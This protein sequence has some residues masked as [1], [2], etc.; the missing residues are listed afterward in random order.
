MSLVR[1][2]LPREQRR[3]IKAAIEKLYNDK[4]ASTKKSTMGLWHDVAAALKMSLDRSFGPHWH[5]LIGSALGFALKHR[6]KTSAVWRVNSEPSFTVV[7]WKSPGYEDL[8][9]AVGLNEKEETGASEE[10]ECKAVNIKVLQPST[11]EEDTEIEKCIAL[12]R[13]TLG[14]IGEK[15]DFQLLAESLRKCFTT[16]MGPV[17]HISVGNDIIAEVATNRRSYFMCSSGKLRIIGFKHEQEGGSTFDFAKIL[18]GIPYALIVIFG[19]VYLTLN[20]KC[21][22]ETL[23]IKSPFWNQVCNME[24]EY[25]LALGGTG[26]LV[27]ISIGKRL[28]RHRN[29]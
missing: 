19:L 26:I 6:K 17:W 14:R 22:N 16:E 1:T 13:K 11:V 20:S 29:K 10:K 21:S 18:K 15:P 12:V 25:Y 9:S 7:I 3:P 24:Y 2:D 8:S 28:M 23:K 27:A 5:V 4:V